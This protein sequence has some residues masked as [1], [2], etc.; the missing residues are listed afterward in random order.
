MKKIIALLLV[1][2]LSLSIAPAAFAATDE[3]LTAADRLYLLGL[4]EGTGIDAEGKPIYELDRAPTRHEAVTM[5]VR[6]LG[7]E[8]EALS[9]KWQTPFTDVVSWAKPYV[10]YAY[11]NGLTDG[12]ETAKFG[13][14]R[15]VTA[16]E[17]LT[18]VL[19]ALGYDSAADF[20]WDAAW[21]LSDSIGLTDGE[22]SAANNADFVRGDV[23]IIS[24]DALPTLMKDSTLTLYKSIC[25]PDV[26]KVMIYTDTD[27][28]RSPYVDCDVRIIGDGKNISDTEATI[29]IRGNTTAEGKKKPYN[30][31]FSAK[32]DVLGMGKAKK[33]CLLA[34]CFE[35]TM[36][37]NALA[38]DL[39]RETGV[40]Y[41]PD[42]RYVDVYLN[43]V[44]LGNYMLT[45][46]VEVGADRVDIDTDNNEY[47]LELD[48]KPEDEDCY[49]F[50]SYGGQ[51]KFAI[52]EPEIDDLTEEQKEYVTSLIAQAEA[53]LD[54]G[55]Y[56]QV[57]KYFDVDSMSS[58]YL[59]LE[60]FRNV[61][62]AHSSTR[63]HIKDGKIYGGPAWDYDLSAGNYSYNY[64]PEMYSDD[65]V[66]Y[67]GLY[68]VEMKW[69][70]LLTGYEEFQTLVEEKFIENFEIFENLYADNSLGTNRI[71]ALVEANSVSIQRNFSE[72]GW[73]IG[74]RYSTL[75]RYPDATYEANVETLRSWL[76]NRAQWLLET[77]EL[78]LPE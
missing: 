68:A 9:G 39:A 69:L 60:F 42:Y 63:F 26:P 74:W 77:W 1:L 61:D 75:E 14:D 28:P 64:Y 48:W 5:L 62:V 34:N 18:F 67:K 33:W 50:Y 38:F 31:K 35:K 71:D 66:T 65:N 12:I 27:I 78:T 4:F 17:Y 2:A 22:Y 30:I 6:L 55:D 58:F 7:K 25:T 44:L 49:Y 51:L 59:F 16:T 23:A 57:E 70:G 45:E 8:E 32:R 36:L 43:D 10:G 21:E 3:S 72:A 11:T 46:A 47:L 53:A 41:T 15:S 19:R 29:K 13:G 54:S 40:P 37:R 56:A 52:N 76:K 24:A 73:G 20:R